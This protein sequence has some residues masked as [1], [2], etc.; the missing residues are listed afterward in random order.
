LRRIKA[1]KIILRS[2]KKSQWG[3]REAGVSVEG[4]A[5]KYV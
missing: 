2:S 3:R 4:I 5:Y 1:T